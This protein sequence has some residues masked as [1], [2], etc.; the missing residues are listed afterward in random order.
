MGICYLNKGDFVSEINTMPLK[1]NSN[2]ISIGM[3][4]M[5]MEFLPSRNFKQAV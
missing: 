1:E 3:E 2:K 5:S 4:S